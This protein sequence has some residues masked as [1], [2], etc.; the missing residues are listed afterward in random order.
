MAARIFGIGWIWTQNPARFR[1]CF[2]FPVR[3]AKVSQCLCA[4][5]AFCMTYP[6]SIVRK[7]FKSIIKNQAFIDVH[8]SGGTCMQ[9]AL[10]V[11]SRLPMADEE[12]FDLTH[13]AQRIMLL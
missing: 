13:W 7:I 12:L 6:T 9:H 10:N 8:T 1:Q 2:A 4:F 3:E 11:E 5:T